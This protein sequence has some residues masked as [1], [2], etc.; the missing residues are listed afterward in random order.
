MALID[1]INQARQRGASD[2]VILQEIEKQNPQKAGVF[3]TARDRGADSA[4]ILD[5]VLRQNTGPSETEKPSI[6]SRISGFLETAPVLKQ[7]GDIGAGLIGRAQTKIS[8]FDAKPPEEQAESLALGFGVA[9]LAG[10]VTKKAATTGFQKLRQAVTP[11]EENVRTVLT[12]SKTPRLADKVT[13]YFKQAEQ[14]KAVTEAKTP[15]EIA[16]SK[17]RP[18]LNSLNQQLSKCGVVV[19]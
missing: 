7:A 17:L 19:A 11:I 4:T 3:K 1:S 5:E 8:E 18:A 15:L 2:D 14:A 6:A 10:Q 9:P 12:T 13:S 16:G